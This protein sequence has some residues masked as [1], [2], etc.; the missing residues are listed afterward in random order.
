MP[1]K[2]GFRPKTIDE[3]ILRVMLAGRDDNRPWGRVSPGMVVDA[4]ERDVSPEYVHNRFSVLNA[5]GYVTR[6]AKGI[7]EIS[8]IGINVVESPESASETE[9]TIDD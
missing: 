8:E 4:L 1:E 3:E 5:A 2:E 7:Y 6:V 9:E